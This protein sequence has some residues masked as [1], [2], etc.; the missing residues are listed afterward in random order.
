MRFRE[1]VWL[2]VVDQIPCGYVSSIP[3][4]QGKA[5]RIMTGAQVPEGADA[6]VML[7]ATE[8]R[9]EDGLT[10]VGFKR[11]IE[12]GKNITPSDSSFRKVI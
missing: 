12:T 8:L 3:I 11:S 7:E 2:E 9:T 1:Q 10:H 6:V 5:S 4:V